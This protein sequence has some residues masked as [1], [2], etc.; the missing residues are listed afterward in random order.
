MNGRVPVVGEMYNLFRT[1]RRKVFGKRRLWVL[2][3]WN[4]LLCD[5]CTGEALP[6]N[7]IYF[8]SGEDQTDGTEYLQR[9]GYTR[10]RK[11][12]AIKRYEKCFLL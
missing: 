4:A 9:L 12:R 8:V 3:C 6:V 7:R 11:E 5:F 2:L 10:C 1:K